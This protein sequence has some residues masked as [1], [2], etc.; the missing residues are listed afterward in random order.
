MG[1]KGLTR[2]TDGGIGEKE[3]RNGITKTKDV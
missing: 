2:D 3:A 1:V